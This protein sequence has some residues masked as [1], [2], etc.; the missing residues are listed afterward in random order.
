MP[1]VLAVSASQDG[2]PVTLVV[3][4]KGCDGLFHGTTYPLAYYNT[5][6]SA[7]TYAFHPSG[8]YH[9]FGDASAK[10][11][12]KDINIRVYAKLVTRAKADAQIGTDQTY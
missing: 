5:E 3:L 6:G 2:H 8:A 4:F 7:E 11:L 10:L 1:D 9:A 12:S